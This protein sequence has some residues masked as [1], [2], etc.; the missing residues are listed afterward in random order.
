MRATAEDFDKV[1]EVT[2]E[3]ISSSLKNIPATIEEFRRGLKSYSQVSDGWKEA[4]KSR[5]EKE[6]RVVRE[7]RKMLQPEFINLVQRQRLGFIVEGTRF[8]KLKRD[9]VMDGVVGKERNKYIYVRLS[10]NHKTLYYGDWND[11][12]NVPALEQLPHKML[13]DD[14]KEFLTGSDCAREGPGGRGGRHKGGS[15][16]PSDHSWLKYAMSITAADKHIDVIPVDLKDAETVFHCWCDAIHALMREEMTSP[17]VQK[18]VD[19]LLSLEV[20]VRLLDVEGIDLPKEP[21]PVPPPPPNYNFGCE[22]R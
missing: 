1:M 20:N 12:K 2:K 11:D 5:G 6:L 9:D 8:A 4:A 7:L 16:N 17:K 19:M 15:G 13:V 14:I 21:P 22:A 18:D 3:Q 10:S